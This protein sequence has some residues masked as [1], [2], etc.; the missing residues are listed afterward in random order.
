MRMRRATARAGVGWPK[1]HGATTIARGVGGTA[2]L[3][4]PFYEAP[5]P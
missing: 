3:V 1:P 5:V 2:A 4:P